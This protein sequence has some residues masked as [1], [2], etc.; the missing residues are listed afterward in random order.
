[1]NFVPLIVSAMV[2]SFSFSEQQSGFI[3]SAD[4]AGYTFGAV[5]SFLVIAKINWKRLTWLSLLLMLIANLVCSQLDEFLFLLPLR[6]LSGVGGGMV[7][8]VMLSVI[9]R[10]RNPEAIYGLW[11]AVLSLISVIGMA[12][13]PGLLQ[14]A[15]LGAAFFV[16]AVMVAVCLPFLNAVPDGAY[17]ARSD[18]TTPVDNMHAVLSLVAAIVVLTAGIG[19]S[20]AFVGQIGAAAGLSVEQVSYSIAISAVGGIIGGMSAGWLGRRLGRLRPIGFSCVGLVAT[21]L[22]LM[23]DSPSYPLF[24]LCC[25]AF[26][27]LWTFVLPYLLGALAELEQSGRALSLGTIAQGAGFMAGPFLASLLL[28]VGGYDTVLAF[29]A[30]SIVLC[31][32]MVLLARRKPPVK[33][34]EN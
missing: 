25:L 10:T 5:V 23:L 11:F 22:V 8:A 16:L 28:Y 31:F 17:N 3:A 2:A 1:M 18:S 14:Q 27:G 20:W 24:T 9:A 33:Q 12:L 6:F 19:S 4:M 34:V 7:T 21:M 26:Y 15:G 29:A 13:F 32:S 30:S